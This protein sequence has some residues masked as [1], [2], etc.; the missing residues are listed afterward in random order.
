MGD[1]MLG[2]DVEVCGDEVDFKQR[3]SESASSG[4]LEAIKA[5]MAAIHFHSGKF[6]ARHWKVVPKSHLAAILKSIHDECEKALPE[7]KGL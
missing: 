7:L 5:S 3:V 1:I 2:S 6:S 4:G